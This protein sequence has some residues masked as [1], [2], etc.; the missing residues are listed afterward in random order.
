M[1]ELDLGIPRAWVG[2]APSQVE[3]S[4]HDRLIFQR[5]HRRHAMTM[6]ECR[7]QYKADFAAREARM[8]WVDYQVKRCGIAPK[9]SAPTAKPSA[10]M[11]H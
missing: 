2:G 9:A 7:A 1:G 11:K 5:V 3:A 4:I 8:S 10:P 6:E